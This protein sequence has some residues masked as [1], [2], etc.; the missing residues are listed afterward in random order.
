MH[1]PL[2]LLLLAPAAATNT[3]LDSSIDNCLDGQFTC[4]GRQCWL[5]QSATT[6]MLCNLPNAYACYP[7]YQ[8]SDAGC[9][10]TIRDCSSANWKIQGYGQWTLVWLQWSV[11]HTQCPAAM[12]C[13]RRVA[14][15]VVWGA[16]A[17]MSVV[18]EDE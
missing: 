7:I 3:C 18:R 5:R 1:A 8:S 16:G 15:R 6:Q 4:S 14:G 17:G 13:V 11:T 10:R 12:A 9:L 2:L